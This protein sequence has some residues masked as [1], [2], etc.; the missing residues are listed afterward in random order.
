MVPAATPYLKTHLGQ[1]PSRT[2]LNR[3]RSGKTATRGGWTDLLERGSLGNQVWVRQ[4]GLGAYP[5]AQH[6]LVTPGQTRKGPKLWRWMQTLHSDRNAG[7]KWGREKRHPLSS[8]YFS[9]KKESEG[10]LPLRRKKGCLRAGLGEVAAERTEALPE[11]RELSNAGSKLGGGGSV[12]RFLWSQLERG[13]GGRG[14]G[15]QG[16]DTSRWEKGSGR[17]TRGIGTRRGFEQEIMS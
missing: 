10:V 8:Q 7:K 13:C 14:R 16:K 3:L 12:T 17:E 11:S 6:V 1:V 2:A 5:G 15:Q 4:A 9:R